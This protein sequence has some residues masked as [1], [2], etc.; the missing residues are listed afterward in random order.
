MNN[1]INHLTNYLIVNKKETINEEIN[2]I[3][4]GDFEQSDLFGLRDLTTKDLEKINQ[5]RRE[6]NNIYNIIEY[7]NKYEESDKNADY[8][9]KI[10]HIVEKCDDIIIKTL[11]TYD[12][13][14]LETIILY[15]IKNHSFSSADSVQNLIY[16]LEKVVDEYKGGA[17]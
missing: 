6:I 16:T 4:Y 11:E 17:E 10:A 15:L 7:L 8:S 2:S 9:E 1:I 13:S 3:I 14:D 5:K 12:T